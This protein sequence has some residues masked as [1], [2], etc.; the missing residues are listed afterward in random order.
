MK[1]TRYLDLLF[2]LLVAGI[3]GQS[4]LAIV[5]TREATPSAQSS[6]RMAVGDTL[7]AVMGNLEGGVPTTIRLAGDAGV[8]TVLYAFHPECVHSHTLA[9]KWAEHF[10]A[11]SDSES[12]V[13]RIAVTNDSAES[14]LAYAERFDWKI[15]VLSVQQLTPPG[16]ESSLLSRTPWVFVFDSVGVLRFEGHGNQ[17]E[18]LMQVVR[19]LHTAANDV[20]P[21]AKESK[22]T[23]SPLVKK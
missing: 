8:V 12:I 22:L 9:P 1:S 18:P 5:R 13:R 4:T 23:P 3:I 14:G 20:N 15:D 21:W 2:T 17:L 11:D 19:E 6:S 16:L 10:S 7:V